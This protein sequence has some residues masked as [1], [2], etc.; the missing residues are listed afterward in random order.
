MIGVISDVHGNYEALKEIMEYFDNNKIE[1]IICLGDVVGY[2]TQVNECCDELR[3]RNVICLMGN[4]DW[5]MVS[6]SFC[7]RSNSVN[8][9][10]D[11]QRKVITNVNKEW[12]AQAKLF[13]Q[14]E[15]FS[16]LHG[17]WTN[18]ID[19]YL[20]PND[21][22]FQKLEDK[23]FISGHTHFQSYYE[24]GNSIYCN[25]GSVG[26]PRD[27]DNR[28]AFAVIDGEKIYLHRISYNIDKVCRLMENHGF[29]GYYYECLLIGAKNLGFIN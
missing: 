24:F 27:G 4:H 8:D 12:L 11:Y 20:N 16:M 2:Y 29:S 26:Q 17:G 21:E 7:P 9:C 6:N 1:D 10:L 23:I 5:Y 28:A 15:R 25:P 13:Y 3:E 22:Y 14:N 19:E 18:P